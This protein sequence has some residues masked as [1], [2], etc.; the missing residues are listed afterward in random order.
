[1]AKLT[2]QRVYECNDDHC[3]PMCCRQGE[4]VKTSVRSGA[5]GLNVNYNA[6]SNDYEG[7]NYSTMRQAVLE[8]RD[9]WKRLQRWFIESVCEPVF[10]QWLRSAL[11]NNAIPGLGA[12]DF[13]GLNQP[14]FYGRRWQWVDPLKDEQGHGEAMNNFTQNPMAVLNEKGIDLDDMAEGWTVFLERMGPIIE[15][16]SKYGFGK[17]AKLGMPPE[18]KDKEDDQGSN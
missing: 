10:E 3:E 6:L 18:N 11:L 13:E 5:S 7:V 1:M 16:A 9:H 4:Q 14:K 15:T 8:D 12:W 2:H 17:A